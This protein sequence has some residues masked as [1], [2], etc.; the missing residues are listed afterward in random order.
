MLERC[1]RLEDVRKARV[2][3]S[4]LAISSAQIIV[5]GYNFFCFK[6]DA[7]AVLATC[8]CFGTGRSQVRIMETRCST[9]MPVNRVCRTCHTALLPSITEFGSLRGVDIVPSQRSW[10]SWM[11]SCSYDSSFVGSAK[12]RF[13]D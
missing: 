1:Y 9:V 6:S 3:F 8:Y 12:G 13:V 2:F 11:S 4:Y 5:Y 10:V 7:C